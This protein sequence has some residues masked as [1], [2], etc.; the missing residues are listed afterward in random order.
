[1]SITLNTTFKDPRTTIV[2]S[3]L[4]FLATTRRTIT[5]KE[6][7]EEVN[8]R[9]LDPFYLGEEISVQEFPTEGRAMGNQ[10]GECLYEVLEFCLKRNLP[11]LSALVVRKSGENKDLPGKGFWKYVVDNN[12]RQLNVNVYDQKARTFKSLQKSI[13]NYYDP[14]LSYVG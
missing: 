9:I 12:I 10:V 14:S 7:A 3:I 5:Y 6:L 4:I 8:Y 13:Y 11:L 2:L 1:M